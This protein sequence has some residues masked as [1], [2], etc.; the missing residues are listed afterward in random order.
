MASFFDITDWNEKPWFNTTGT[1]DK[2]IVEDQQGQLYYFKTS[3]KK[4][5]MDYK[6]EFWSEIIASK[7]GKALGFNTLNYEIAVRGDK[8]GC[9]SK[10]MNIDGESKLTEGISFL[11][12]YDI[13]YN[14]EEKESQST[15]SYQFIYDSLNFFNQDKFI[16]EIDKI[17]IFDSI[18]GNG[19]RHQENWGVIGNYKAAAKMMEAI[20]DKEKNVFRKVLIHVLSLAFS[21][22]DFWQNKYAKKLSPIMPGYFAPIYDNGSCLGRELSDQRLKQMLKDKTML[23]SYINKGK[24]EIH[25][26]GKKQKH[27]DLIQKIRTLKEERIDQYIKNVKQKYSQ[28]T[29]ESIVNNIDI[30]LPA[31][32]K[33]NSLPDNRKQFIIKLINLRVLKLFELIK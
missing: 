15:Y 3:I 27:I 33:E 22:K 18:I 7:I 10:S 21:N 30:N 13:S 16:A 19:D 14:P 29:I 8:I 31:D 4:E 9:L 23:S 6:F 25:W 17:I 1:R 2:K 26:D 11:T 24:S 32:L 12:G 20:A 5:V 28:Q